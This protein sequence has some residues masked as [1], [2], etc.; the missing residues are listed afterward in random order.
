MRGLID[1]PVKHTVSTK[2]VIRDENRT[3]RTATSVG[4]PGPRSIFPFQTP[5]AWY[6]QTLMGKRMKN[7]MQ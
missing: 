3:S 1:N 2:T 4:A 7:I 5:F 6:I